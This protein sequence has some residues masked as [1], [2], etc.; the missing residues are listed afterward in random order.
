MSLPASWVDRLFAKL[1]VTYGQGF[2]R[3]YEGIPITDVK[4]N[5][6]EELAGFQQSPD[7]IRYGLTYLPPSK[8]PT[9]LEFRDLCRKAPASPLALVAPQGEPPAP[10][11]VAATRD[12]FRALSQRG[13]KD[14]AY[15]LREREG[16]G[17]GLTRFQRDAWREALANEVGA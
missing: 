3:Q 4:A 8:A 11:V 16:R 10:E 15:A 5:W 2:L 1:T 9:V 6:A 7:S 14:W 17:K 13:D 12:A